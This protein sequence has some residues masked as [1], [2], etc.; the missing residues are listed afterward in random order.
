MLKKKKKE[1]PLNLKIKGGF[2]VELVIE[3]DFNE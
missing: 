3:I 2:T 1:F